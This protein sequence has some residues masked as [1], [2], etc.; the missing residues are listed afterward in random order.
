[1]EARGAV[2]QTDLA[3]AS[4]CHSLSE[5]LSRKTVTRSAHAASH[6]TPF[7]ERVFDHR[8]AAD[9]VWCQSQRSDVDTAL[10]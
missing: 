9:D 2:S 1:V 5:R 6:S 10:N 7:I 4:Y 3:R 8:T